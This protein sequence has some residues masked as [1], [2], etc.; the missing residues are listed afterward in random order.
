M[1]EISYDTEE[2][3]NRI[4]GISREYHYVCLA[5]A[6]AEIYKEIPGSAVEN[7]MAGSGPIEKRRYK[8]KI[9]GVP[10]NCNYAY[11][12]SNNH[13]LKGDGLIETPDGTYHAVVWITIK[14]DNDGGGTR[15]IK[16]SLDVYG[17]RGDMTGNLADRFLKG[18]LI[19]GLSLYQNCSDT[20]LQDSV[21]ALWEGMQEYIAMRD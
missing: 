7:I 10:I 16:V 14:T 3:K 4:L 15:L 9:E 1:V 11:S 20:E 5:E 2:L 12:D 6:V 21:D 13:L 8:V 17:D 18:V 19:E